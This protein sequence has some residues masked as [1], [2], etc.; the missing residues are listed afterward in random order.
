[1]KLRTTVLLLLATSLLAWGQNRSPVPAN[2]PAVTETITYPF[3]VD[4]ARKVRD[5]QLEWDELEIANQKMLVIIEQNKQKQ[6]ADEDE[7]AKLA[8]KVA[9]DLKVDLSLYEGDARE[10]KF[11]PKKKS[12]PKPKD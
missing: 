2:Q 6:K 7:I 1:M 11:V 8:Y 9:S 3:P 5:R 10:L 4:V 12:Q